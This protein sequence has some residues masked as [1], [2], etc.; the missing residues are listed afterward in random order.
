[1]TEKRLI[2]EGPN[3]VANR[4]LLTDADGN[5]YSAGG[6]GGG[7]GGG[8]VTVADGADVA[9]G[10][11]ADAAATTDTGTFSI[12]ALV[13]RGLT[14]WT[15]LLGRIP[16]LVSG[17]MPVDGSAVTQPVSAASLPLPSGA[18]TSALQ[19]TGNTSLG[20][21]DTKLPSPIIT[22]L[23]PVDTLATPTRMVPH[24]LTSVSTS[25]V[26]LA[27]TR[28]VSVDVSVNAVLRINA[29]ASVPANGTALADAIAIPAGVTKDFDVPASTTLHFVRD[30]T[31]DGTI[32]ITE[33][34]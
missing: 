6:G 31:A 4:V 20:S 28:R 32:R 10:A 19:T 17:R 34:T 24:A 2:H 23:F 7:G 30:A 11:R 12:V 25:V 1:M 26:L 22:G 18:S 15:T 8:A 9:Q 14:N 21:I 3:G 13:K 16:T 5:P 29:I 33:L 27:G